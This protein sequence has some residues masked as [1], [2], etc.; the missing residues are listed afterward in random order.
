MIGI[1]ASNGW[2]GAD[3]TFICPS[4]SA[5]APLLSSD[6]P[7]ASNQCHG[8]VAPC[9]LMLMRRTIAEPMLL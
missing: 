4:P 2:P 5:I 3:S 8:R 9:P 1:S 7:I 6:R